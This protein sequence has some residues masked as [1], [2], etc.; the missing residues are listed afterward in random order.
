MEM[1]GYPVKDLEISNDGLG[2]KSQD[3]APEDVEIMEG[4]R[5]NPK[6]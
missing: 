2:D 5:R 1:K 3:I 4:L 6:F